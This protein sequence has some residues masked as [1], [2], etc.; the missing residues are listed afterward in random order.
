M[1]VTSATITQQIREEAARLADGQARQMQAAREGFERG[2]DTLG[3]WCSFSSA[4]IA[5]GTSCG[6]LA[7]GRR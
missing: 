4:P 2:Q 3:A 5:T 7:V 1:Q 6:P